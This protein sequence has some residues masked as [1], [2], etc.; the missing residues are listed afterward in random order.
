MASGS[1]DTDDGYD[2]GTCHDNYLLIQPV[3]AS[4]SDCHLSLI[5][6]LRLLVG[7]VA[8][9]WIVV[10]VVV[11]VELDGENDSKTGVEPGS[12]LVVGLVLVVFEGPW[13]FFLE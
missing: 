5:Y 13:M 10:A 1:I 6:N 7:V 9:V 11:V 12:C 2:F 8:F 4:A 3:G